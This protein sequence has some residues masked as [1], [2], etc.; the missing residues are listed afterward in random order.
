MPVL[1]IYGSLKV[2]KT[3]Q[4]VTGL[5]LTE[6]VPASVNGKM[7]M[8]ENFPVA[9]PDE[10]KKIQGLLIEVPWEILQA[11]DTFEEEGRLLIRREVTAFTPSGEKEQAYIYWG[12]P[13]HPV[14]YNLDSF[15]EVEEGIW[16]TED[17]YEL[18][19]R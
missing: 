19:V 16:I 17:T 10:E 15:Q 11:I 1:F 12:N 2:P 3:F 7:V 18:S 9:F 5:Y 13:Q 4:S 14:F 8:Y 6:S